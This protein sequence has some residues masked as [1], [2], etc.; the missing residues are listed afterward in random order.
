[1]KPISQPPP[2]DWIIFAS[3]AMSLGW[4][5]RGFIGGGPLGAMIPGA[6][7][8]LVLA[9][10]LR[11]D[12]AATSR[13]IAF[14]AVGIGFGGDMTYGQTAG[15]AMKPETF[16]WA[17]LGFAIKGAVWGLLGGAT[18]GLALVPPTRRYLAITMAAML[19]A[20]WAG[21]RVIN[22]PKLIYFSNL[23]DRPRPEVWAGLL[24]A[25]IT[26]AL[27]HGPL[28]RRFALCGAIGGGIGFALGACFQVLGRTH[29]AG[30]FFSDW[31]KVMELTFGALLGASYAWAAWS[32]EPMPDTPTPEPPRSP[33]LASIT[34]AALAIAIAIFLVPL[35]DRFHVRF[36]Y[37]VAG[38]LLLL[39]ATRS[40]DIARQIGLTGTCCA[41]FIDLY[42]DRPQTEPWLAVLLIVIATIAIAVVVLRTT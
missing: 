42:E 24:L 3:V 2:A 38:A 36:S 30:F 26:V 15:L 6:M 25:G 18:I 10:L 31:W 16:S 34:G 11:L 22:E 40:S 41:F 14:A 32:V 8:G 5:L 19:A 4:G 37:T 33:L 35:I 27:M 13:L 23:F 39:L 21:W 7:I 17:L 29:A 1:M 9:L 12:T 28:V 20:T